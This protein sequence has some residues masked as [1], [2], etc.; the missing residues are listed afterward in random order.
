MLT[1]L[2]LSV[3]ERK[4]QIPEYMAKVMSSSLK[5]NFSPL[6]SPFNN[7]SHLYQAPISSAHQN[8]NPDGILCFCTT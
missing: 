5:Y 7:L 6:Q 1:V 4:Q 8:E 3:A 2:G